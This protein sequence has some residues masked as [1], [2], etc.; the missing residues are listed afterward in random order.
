M[1]F[2]ESS[3]HL[4][5]F[6]EL[7]KTIKKIKISSNDILKL[8]LSLKNEVYEEYIE[9]HYK[10][11]DAKLLQNKNYDQSEINEAMKEK[12]LRKFFLFNGFSKLRSNGILPKE[13][14]ENFDQE[15]VLGNS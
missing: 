7:S 15:V 4:P 8:R 6:K 12:F 2:K 14:L 5:N 11:G 10:N 13:V 9:K 1:V 3:A